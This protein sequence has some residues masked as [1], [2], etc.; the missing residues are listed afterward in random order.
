MEKELNARQIRLK[1]EILSNKVPE[2]VD[3]SGIWSTNE[4]SIPYHWGDIEDLGY[5]KTKRAY[6]G[7]NELTR[8]YSGPNSIKLSPHDKI[9]TTNTYHADWE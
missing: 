2:V 3:C 8:F 4:E 6:D 7:S 1:E 9:L 5:G